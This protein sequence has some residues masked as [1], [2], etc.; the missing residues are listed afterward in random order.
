MV[1]VLMG[2]LTLLSLISQGWDHTA[3]EGK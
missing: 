3:Y 1:M 2:L